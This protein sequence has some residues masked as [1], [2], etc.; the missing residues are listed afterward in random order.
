MH[1]SSDAGL[2]FPHE[3][4]L[5]DAGEAARRLSISPRYLW[6]ETVPRGSIPC[7]RQGRRVLYSVESLQAWVRSQEQ[8][9]T[10]SADTD[11]S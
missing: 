11:L 1:H 4:I 5:V 6:D 8:T 9:A 2:Q 3:P 7:V 10:V